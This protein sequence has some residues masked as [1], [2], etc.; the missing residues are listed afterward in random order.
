M[1]ALP[2]AHW[3]DDKLSVADS[4]GVQWTLRDGVGMMV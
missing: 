2:L 1:L 3:A 4:R